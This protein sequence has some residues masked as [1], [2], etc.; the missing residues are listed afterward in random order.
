[1]APVTAYELFTLNDAQLVSDVRNDP[2]FLDSTGQTGPLAAVLRRSDGNGGQPIGV[3]NVEHGEVGRLTAAHRKTLIALANL[4]VIAIENADKAN[5]LSRSNAIA[6]MGAWGADIVHDIHRE[7]AV[8]RLAIETLRLE[9]MIP[10]DLLLKRL[11]EIDQA[12]N[13]L[14][15]PVL[16]EQL[17]EPSRARERQE[18]CLPDA[19]IRAELQ[20]LRRVHGQVTFCLE[21][22]CPGLLI[23][24]HDLWLRRLLRHLVKNAIRAN[25][26]SLMALTIT[27]GTT[28]Q[29]GMVEVWV[30]DNG[31][32]V[33][34]EIATLLF[35]RPIPHTQER[36]DERF[37]RGLLLVRHIVE[38]HGGQV[39][40]KENQPG[41]QVCFAF[42]L[43][44]ATL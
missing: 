25:E 21:L 13:N 39:W 22:T 6:I 31:R 33:R 10:R 42:C 40:L 3:L 1:M 20:Q 8:V 36:L 5:Q 11:Q 2:D 27:I 7:V 41:E 17:P 43:P 44:Q 12:V 37:G 30:Q 32:G 34:P 23:Q 28:Q 29:P 38:L 26:Q 18:S 9:E 16:P 19:V 24:M 15:M 14:V 4:A 35:N